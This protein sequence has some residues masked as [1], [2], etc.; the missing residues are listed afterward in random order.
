MI[1]NKVISLIATCS[2][3]FCGWGQSFKFK[4]V[5]PISY[6]EKDVP[7]YALPN[8]LEC[9]DGTIVSTVKQ[10]EKKRRGEVL[11]F[12]SVYMYG[13]VP[14]IDSKPQWKILKINHNALEGKAIRKDV[15]IWPIGTHKEYKIDV[16]IYL[17]PS[18]KSG[19]VPLF[20][21]PA[22]LPNYT[23]CNDSDIEKPDSILIA[24]GKR[25]K[26]YRK[27]AMA[28]FWNLEYILSRGY[29]LATFCHQDIEPDT[30]EDFVKGFPS[31]FYLSGQHFPF[32]DEWGS[33]SLWAWQ[34]SRVMDYIVTDRQIDSK[35]VVAI[36]HSRFGKTALWAA[37][38]DQRFSMAISNNSGCGGA[39]ISRRCYG[40]TIEYLN[41]RYPHWFCGNFKQFGNRELY[42]PFDQ[43]EL[44]AL[45]AP[46]PVYIASAE[47]DKWADPKGEYLAGKEATP[48]YHLYGLEGLECDSMPELEK[49]VANGYIGYH[50]RKGKHTMTAYDWKQY[51]D[52]AD[53]KIKTPK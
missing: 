24:D 51:M 21:A 16:Q 9:N 29:G 53:R 27:G 33:V 32:P 3:F 31:L 1:L 23:V 30:A 10:W 45:I 41:I 47:D 36:G 39:A 8:V 6:E 44:I 12:F 48:V 7:L 26:A 18:A 49:P 20:L 4:L 5:R 11:D 40:E 46:R 22:L 42:M 35:K 38:Q 34:M 2:C 14:M 25:S 28:D 17:P 37:A 15:R 43:H 50:I 19:A 52:F 13:K